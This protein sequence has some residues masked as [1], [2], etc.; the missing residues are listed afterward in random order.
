[1]RMSDIISVTIIG[2][3]IIVEG[4]ASDSIFEGRAMRLPGKYLA[5]LPKNSVKG[6]KT[7]NPKPANAPGPADFAKALD[8]RVAISSSKPK[9]YKDINDEKMPSKK[10]LPKK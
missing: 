5:N 9:K 3:I 6:S 4:S 7:N 1:M 8:E 10:P 2:Q